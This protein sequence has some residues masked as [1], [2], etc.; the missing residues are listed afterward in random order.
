MTYG[1]GLSYMSWLMVE[2]SSSLVVA[3]KFHNSSHLKMDG[4]NTSFL[5]GMAYFQGL[6]LLVSGSVSLTLC[7]HISCINQ[8]KHFLQKRRNKKLG[9][10]FLGGTSLRGCL[11][12]KVVFWTSLTLRTTPAVETPP[13]PRST[14]PKSEPSNDAKKP[15]D[16]GVCPTSTAWAPQKGVIFLKISL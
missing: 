3:I 11:C 6:W 12:C 14:H 4:W 1:P 16:H 10:I 7:F 5:L 13:S 15:I 9:L 2:R 8:L